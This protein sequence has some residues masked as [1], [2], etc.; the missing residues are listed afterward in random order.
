MPSAPACKSDL[1][2]LRSGHALDGD[3]LVH[4][5]AAAS[6]GQGGE[7]PLRP[8]VPNPNPE[9]AR[10]RSSGGKR[11]GR[12][13]LA[14]AL[15]VAGVTGCQTPARLNRIDLAEPGWRVEQG[16]AIWRLPA[17]RLDLAGEMTFA[18]HA[19]GRCFFQFSK[20]PFTLVTGQCSDMRWQIEF[21]P[22]RLAFAGRGDPPARFAW[23]QLGRALA[24]ERLAS[25]W[26]FDGRTDGHWRLENSRTG[27]ALEG[28]LSP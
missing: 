28:Y 22:R 4:P 17:R 25:P 5:V 3:P 14:C 18:L 15:L 2:P 24:G 11:S 23:L 8:A 19:D 20:T 7:S 12:I 9:I 16:Q 6:A 1:H 10:G 13:W 27:E 26:R 21:P